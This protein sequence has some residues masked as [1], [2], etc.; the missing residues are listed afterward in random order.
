MLYYITHHV[1]ILCCR[2]RAPVR[3]G[4]MEVRVCVREEKSARVHGHGKWKRCN[5]SSLL[6]FPNLTSKLYM[7]DDKPIACPIFDKSSKGIKEELGD[8]RLSMDM[9]NEEEDEEV[10]KL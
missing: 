4:E 8:E 1:S 5:G 6:P 2:F 9:K 3:R 7:E 10:I